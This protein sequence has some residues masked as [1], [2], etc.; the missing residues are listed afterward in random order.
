MVSISSIENFIKRAVWKLTRS[1]PLIKYIPKSINNG[2]VIGDCA[3][4]RNKQHTYDVFSKQRQPIK[5]DIGNYKVAI[6]VAT[7]M[8]QYTDQLRTQLDKLLKLDHDYTENY[9]EYIRHKHRANTQKDVVE[10]LQ[11][12][13]TVISGK[14][15]VIYESMTL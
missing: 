1:S 7:L 6:C 13:L 12:R 11:G 10:Y 9:A 14:I 4:I 3:V 8:N 2:V 5:K 15:D